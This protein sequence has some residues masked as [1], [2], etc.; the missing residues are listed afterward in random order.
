MYFELDRRLDHLEK[1]R[2]TMDSQVVILQKNLA[3][4]QDEV[5][6]V[7]AE[8]ADLQKQLAAGIDAEDEAAIAGVNVGLAQLSLDLAAVL[9]PVPT[10]TGATG[11]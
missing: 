5:K 10:P 8:I 7:A 9:P 2:D 1:W 6:A 3:T 4:L 11:A